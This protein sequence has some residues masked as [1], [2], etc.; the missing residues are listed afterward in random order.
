MLHNALVNGL[1]VE[2]RGSDGEI[3]TEKVWL[4]DFENPENNEFLAVN[5]LTVMQDDFHRRPDIVLYV[6]GLPLGLIE[7]K[8]PTDEN[9]G[10]R[11]AFNQ[12]Q[13]Y[14]MELPTFFR[15]NEFLIISDGLDAEI[16][17]LSADFERF[18]P[19]KTI[20][21]DKEQL[22]V[23]MLEVLLRGVC[24]KRR[25][26]DIIRSFIVFE[27]ETELYVKKLAAYHQYWAVHRALESTKSAIQPQADH[28]VG[29]VWHTQGSGKSLSMVFY[30]GKLVL[31]EHRDF[32]NPTIVMIT[33]RNDLDDQLFET[34]ANCSDLLR[35]SPKQA[36]S[37]SNLR[38]LL[39]V[40]SGG[41]IFTTNAKFLPDDS[42]EHQLLSDRTNIIVM[43]DEAH[44]SQYNFI[45]GFARHVREALPNASFIG[46]T[47]TPI[48]NKDKSTPAVFGDYIDVYDIQQ[49]VQDGTTVPIYY[50]S[51]LIELDI[52]ESVRATI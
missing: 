44:R 15:F 30:A 29:V 12:I 51:R 10:L 42:G 34:F 13:T 52:N 7:L 20:G 38:E 49:A 37:S 14:R 4:F 27:K 36:T 18:T 24:D 28:R 40:E 48:E 33:D 9:T 32:K 8:D 43:A 21:G 45:D 11:K 16:G 41:I 19:W 50:D 5:Q 6:N 35:Q 3:R 17:T 31:D 25:M 1:D 26:L 46:F 47:G 22:R 2:H 39:R 23:P